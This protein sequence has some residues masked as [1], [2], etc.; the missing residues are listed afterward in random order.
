MI[1]FLLMLHNII[2]FL[3]FTSAYPK[4]LLPRI[5]DGKPCWSIPLAD[6]IPSCVSEMAATLAQVHDIGDPSPVRQDAFQKSVRIFRQIHSLLRSAIFRIERAS[7]TMR[8]SSLFR[9]SRGVS[10]EK[11]RKALINASGEP[12]PRRRASSPTE[13]VLSASCRRASSIRKRQRECP[14]DSFIEYRQ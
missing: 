11:C 6:S 13:M 10:P 4:K 5:I 14:G 9:Y 8:R 2:Y 3:F 7:E 12:Y 1:L